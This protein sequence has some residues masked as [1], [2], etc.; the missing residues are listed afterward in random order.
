[1]RSCAKKCPGTASR[2]GWERVSWWCRGEQGSGGL[3]PGRT[4]HDF[5]RV[6]RLSLCTQCLHIGVFVAAMADYC[7][8]ADYR[9]AKRNVSRE[10]NGGSTYTSV[11]SDDENHPLTEDPY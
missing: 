10:H 9:E 1:M 3:A 7:S 11:S 2:T 6:S 8:A 5:V 4:R